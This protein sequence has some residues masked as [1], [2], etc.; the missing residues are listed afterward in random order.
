M[1]RED[2]RTILV[3]SKAF[4][5]TNDSTGS[6]WYSSSDVT[7]N[8]S[9]LLETLYDLWTLPVKFLLDPLFLVQCLVLSSGL[10]YLLPKFPQ[11]PPCPCFG[12]THFWLLN[13][14]HTNPKKAACFP[15]ISFYFV[16]PRLHFDI[17]TFSHDF[18]HFLPCY[19]E[20]KSHSLVQSHVS[21]KHS[22]AR[23]HFIFRTGAAAVVSLT[24][25]FID[26]LIGLYFIISSP[27]ALIVSSFEHI[28]GD[29][30]SQ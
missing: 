7:S 17:G 24:L 3:K 9:F 1:A 30:S 26:S 19:S 29:L 12:R 18:V 25:V 23:N 21:D 28:A 13:H 27:E 14:L 4:Q 5:K 20:V 15:H 10:N 8:V 11:Q 6:I 2:F 16:T 22:G